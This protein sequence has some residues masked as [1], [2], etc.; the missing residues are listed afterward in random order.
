V[1]ARKGQASIA[2]YTGWAIHANSKNLNK[3]LLH[4]KIP[5]PEH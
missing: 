1:K 2:S 4:E 5:R 3:K